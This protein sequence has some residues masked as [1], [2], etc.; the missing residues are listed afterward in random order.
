MQGL[1][2]ERALSPRTRA[3]QTDTGAAGRA[4]GSTTPTLVGRSLARSERPVYLSSLAG[5]SAVPS[6][7]QSGLSTW[8][9]EKGRKK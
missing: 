4:G 6:H 2:I 1:N 5:Q 7:S 8:K 3:R 9:K